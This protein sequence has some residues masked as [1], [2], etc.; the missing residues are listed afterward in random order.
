MIFLLD[1]HEPKPIDNKSQSP[2][3]YETRGNIRKN[4]DIL[5]LVDTHNERKIQSN[6]IFI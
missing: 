2:K 4:V 1:G 3:V 5:K 6:K